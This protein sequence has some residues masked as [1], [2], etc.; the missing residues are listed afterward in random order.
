MNSV[1]PGTELGVCKGV[2]LK[3]TSSKGYTVQIGEKFSFLRTYKLLNSF[4]SREGSCVLSEV[5]QKLLLF[6]IFNLRHGV[7]HFSIPLVRIPGS[8]A[9]YM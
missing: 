9:A 7:L 1:Y 3:P 5:V 2:Q 4:D 6:T 8:I